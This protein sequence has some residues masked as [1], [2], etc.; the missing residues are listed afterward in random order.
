MGCLAPILFF[1]AV[2]VLAFAFGRA[3]SIGG[4]NIGGL[5]PLELSLLL[6]FVV[7]GLWT[8]IVWAAWFGRS[9]G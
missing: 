5:G 2:I 9:R 6:A 3:I 4:L 1:C 8:L 7:S